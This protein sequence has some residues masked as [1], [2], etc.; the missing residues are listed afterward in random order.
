MKAVKAVKTVENRAKGV[1][2]S[3]QTWTEVHLDR[4]ERNVRT[5]RSR[6]PAGCKM[7]AVVKADGYGHGAVQAAAAAIRAGA[8]ELAVSRLDE[9][10]RLRQN[11][12]DVPILTLGPIAPRE[13]DIAAEHQIAVPVFQAEW[14]RDMRE[15]RTSPKPLPV[16]IKMDTG[17]GR[18]GIRTKREFEEML[19][20]LAAGGIDVKGVY[21]HLATANQAD[22][23]YCEKQLA[24]FAEMR[25][26]LDEAGFRDVT[27]H[28]AN[29]AAALRDPVYAMDMVRVG[30]SIFGIHTCDEEVR[31]R[32][33]VPLLPT[34]SLHTTIIHVKRVAAGECIGYDRSYTAQD[35]EWIATVPLGYGDGCFRGYAGLELLV[36]GER[37]PIVGNICMDQLMI[38]LPRHYPVGTQA[39][40][41]GRQR[42]ETVTLD[43]LAR[44]IGTIPQQVLLMIAARVPRV[45]LRE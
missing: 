1:E 40:L 36:D 11:G 43:D 30:A 45:Y 44:H 28:C 4:I 19:P 15:S 5:I 3:Y 37:A 39:T 18:I 32:H 26:W 17:M 9:A 12:I 42:D 7:M 25:G 23:G 29:S 34:L 20:L 33:G 10:V 6:L 14:L 16:H 21:T 27:A 24:R 13:A 38:R 22:T 8:D 35:D 31:G 2:L 41:I